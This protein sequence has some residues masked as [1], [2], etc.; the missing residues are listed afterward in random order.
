MPDSRLKFETCEPRF[1]LSSVPYMVA[2][3]ND[4][5]DGVIPSSITAVGEQVFF[6]A[7]DS[8]HGLELWKSNGAADGTVLVKDIN[9]NGSA[10]HQFAPLVNVAGVLYFYADDGAHGFE[11]WKSDGTAAGTVM[12]KDIVAGPEG[13]FPRNL[14]NLNGALLFGANDGVNGDE[15]WRSNG[16]AAGTYLLRDVYPGQ[17]VTPPRDFTQVNQL[18]YFVGDDA[19]GSRL[20]RT[21]GTTAGTV[22]LSPTNVRHLTNVNGQLVFVDNG[23]LWKMTASSL[24][25]LT[26]GSNATRDFTSLIN[27]SGTL[28]FTKWDSATGLELWKSNGTQAG[29][30]RIKDIQPGSSDSDPQHL[31]NVSGTLFFAAADTTFN[32]ELWKSDGT[33]EGTV[34]VKEIQD[35]WQGSN[36][37]YLTN[38]NGSLYFR[39][40]GGVASRDEELWK[41]DGTAAGTRRVMD[42]M[43]GNKGSD[44]RRFVNAAG[45][46]YF[47][48]N[49]GAHGPEVWSLRPAPLGDYTADGKVD[50]ADF[51]AWQRGFG[52][53]AVPPGSGADGS[54]DG[55]IDGADLQVWKAA[56]SSPE[57]PATL[58][59]SVEDAPIEE[60]AVDSIFSSGDFTALFTSESAADR[61]RLRNK[62]R[63]YRDG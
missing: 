60:R 31:T 42:I 21:D 61:I 54:G 14:Y 29:T 59:A 8:Q 6:L 26:S 16:T 20:W 19:S 40:E 5:N 51:L 25:N 41:S 18:A 57:V 24:T 32:N 58:A 10:F 3:I 30:A 53:T 9:P 43:P 44:P 17:G 7:S 62:V 12:V 56:Y 47:T 36:P 63:A 27:V 1:A 11:L 39:A 22:A 2:D 50:G 55:L 33:P 49:D 45:K 34:K 28:F 52:G 48:A 15:L 4:A 35:S 13:S 46:L 23:G 38:V 37:V